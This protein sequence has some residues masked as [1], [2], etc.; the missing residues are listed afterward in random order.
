MFNGS[1]W[2]Y[3]EAAPLEMFGEPDGDEPERRTRCTCGAFLPKSWT[4]P[5]EVYR[6]SY[7]LTEWRLIPGCAGDDPNDYEEV[8]VGE[9]PGPVERD[10]PWTV[11]GR[12]GKSWEEGDL[13]T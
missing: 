7:P 9:E 4:H 5:E 13:W 8:V 1:Y 2:A 3:R 11:C 6:R 12:C 10:G